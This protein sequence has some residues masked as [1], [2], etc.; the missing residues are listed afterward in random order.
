MYYEYVQEMGRQYGMRKQAA[1]SDGDYTQSAA[2]SLLQPLSTMVP[3]LAGVSV[4][5]PV[6][7]ASRNPASLG[8]EDKRLLKELSDVFTKG[9]GG[10]FVGPD[11]IKEYL[12]KGV[13]SGGKLQRL[14]GRLQGINEHM[15]DADAMLIGKK[16]LGKAGPNYSPAGHFIYMPGK[17]GMENVGGKFGD[18]LK[19]GILAHE[20]GHS[21]NLGGNPKG[22]YPK[23]YAGSKLGSMLAMN[24]AGLSGLMLDDSSLGYM[25]GAGA[26]VSA[27]MLAEEIRAS[28]RGYNLMRRLG[29]SRLKALAAFSGVPSYM[30]LA[31]ASS[32]PWLVR[33]IDRAV[34]E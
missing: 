8:A 7:K 14:F 16:M 9:S 13:E 2:A 30:G 21:M 34:Q 25:G 24:A 31:A 32:M 27:P 22:L 17:G 5:V 6:M 1:Y 11:N 33:K 23:L 19:P 29:G 12:V 15:S 26:A 18:H 4:M 20:I 10:R 28:A 3:N